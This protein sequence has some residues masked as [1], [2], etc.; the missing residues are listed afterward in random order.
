MVHLFC[1]ALPLALC[2]A[3]E[4]PGL[5]QVPRLIRRSRRTEIPQGHIAVVFQTVRLS[6]RDENAVAGCNPLRLAAH[7]HQPTAFEDEVHL[8]WPMAMKPLL[9]ARLKN[10][11]GGGQMLGASGPRRGQQVRSDPLRAHVPWGRL[12]REDVHGFLLGRSRLLYL[13]GTATNA[14]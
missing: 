3:M 13:P 8:L 11:Q 7:G 6:R 14:S 1:G 2:L 4:R 10:S 9:A 5:L 12:F